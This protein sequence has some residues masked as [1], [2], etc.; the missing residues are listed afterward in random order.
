MTQPVLP[1]AP[2][3]EIE[4]RLK[5]RVLAIGSFLAIMAT[6]AVM[7]AISLLVP[8]KLVTGLPAD[9][10]LAAV[11]AELHGRLPVR[12]GALRFHSALT[13]EAPIDTAF[14]AGQAALVESAIQSIERARARHRGDPRLVVALAHLDLALA[15]AH[16]PEASAAVPPEQF[17][18]WRRNVTRAERRYR[19]VTNRGVDSPE[20]RLGL[21]IALALEA[22]AERDPLR[23]RA[24]KLEAIAQWAAVDPRDGAALPALYDRA[25]LLA[26]VKRHEEATRAAREYLALDGTSPWAQRLREALGI[27]GP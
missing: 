19:A 13:G 3:V 25:L 18:A 22:M 21:G 17:A 6:F 27:A 12:A 14:G 15:A 2:V 1:P 23:E 7:A 16:V 4:R 26:E 24:L 5:W 10:E 20:A 8:P 11:R 9:P